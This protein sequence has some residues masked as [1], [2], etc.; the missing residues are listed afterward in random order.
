MKNN[1]SFLSHQL[2]LREAHAAVG[3]SVLRLPK[4]DRIT[5]TVAG[6]LCCRSNVALITI[7]TL[8]PHPSLDCQVAAALVAVAAHLTGAAA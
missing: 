3:V 2:V 5:T 1:D 6:P 8:R 7:K 4:E